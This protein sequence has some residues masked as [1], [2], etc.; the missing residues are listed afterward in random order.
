MNILIAIP[1]LLHGGTEMQ[2]LMLVRA[3]KELEQPVEGEES[4]KAGWTDKAD[5]L[6]SLQLDG[7]DLASRIRNVTADWVT[8]KL[9]TLLPI[10]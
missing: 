10:K 4:Y 5:S 1:C 7:N 6:W 9:K 3:L 8:Q 2:T